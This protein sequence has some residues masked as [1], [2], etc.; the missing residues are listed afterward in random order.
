MV[1]F[2]IVKE[3]Y[4]LIKG[5]KIINFQFFFFFLEKEVNVTQSPLVMEN[6]LLLFLFLFW[7]LFKESSNSC[8]SLL[9]C[10]LNLISILLLMSLY[11]ACF[12]I[13]FVLVGCLFLFSYSYWYNYLRLCRF[14][15]AILLY[16]VYSK[17]YYLH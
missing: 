12:L 16:S 14:I 5:R 13:F 10:Y 11:N 3:L 8:V 9:V 6:M 15:W 2:S 4:F 7:L 1:S 17:I